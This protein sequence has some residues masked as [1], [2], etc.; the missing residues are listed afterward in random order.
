MTAY[1]WLG[2]ALLASGC[3]GCEADSGRYPEGWTFSVD[4]LRSE[5]D[6]DVRVTTSLAVIGR[7]GPEGAPRTR[8]AVLRLFCERGAVGVT[9]STDQHLPDKL[10]KSRIKLDSLPPYTVEGFAGY[11]MVS[12]GSPPG[13]FLDSLRGH[14]RLLI[15]YTDG[16]GGARTISEFA[17]AGADS[18]RVSFLKACAE[19]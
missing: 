13:P 17:I 1:R 11:G 16:T 9:I 19:R 5:M 7:E 15:E 10:I 4:T 12:V 2:C 3:G 18:Y 8:P 6:A 14:D